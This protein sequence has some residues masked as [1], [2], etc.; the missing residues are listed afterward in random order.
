MMPRTLINVGWCLGPLCALW[1]LAPGTA[2]GQTTDQIDSVAAGANGEPPALPALQ[3]VRIQGSPPVIDGDLSDPAWDVAP[4]ATDFVQVYP[5]E[6]EPASE[7]T[8]ARVLYDDE[9][10]YVAIRAWDSRP[11]SVAAQLTRRDQISGSDMVH[12]IIDSY[13]DRRTAFHFAVNPL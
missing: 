2:W 3:A 7:P 5:R 6:G 8:E 11:D 13:F 1:I 9:A 10:I 4:L 12:V